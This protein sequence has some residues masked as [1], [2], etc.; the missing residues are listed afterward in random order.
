MKITIT[1]PDSW[2]E[3]K[4][5]QYLEYTK[6]VKPWL[7]SE[8]YAE[9]SIQSALLHFCKVPV[10]YINKLPKAVADKASIKLGELF[11]DI[12][13][14][15][16]VTEFTVGSTMYG[17]I[18]ALNDMTY[19]EYLDLVAYTKKDMWDNIPTIMSILYRPITNRVGKLYTIEPYSGT[20]ETRLELF[21]HVL[22]MDVVFG[23]LS[24][25]LGLQKDLLLGILT[26][27]MEEMKKIKDPEALA[28]LQDLAES[29]Q[30]IAQLQSYLITTLRN[31]TL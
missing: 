12:N 24:F 11:T 17:F 26:Y 7:E 19:G 25:F 5:S 2:A 30:D 9:K 18:P 22:T 21:K 13:K 14:K 4:L 10:E 6:H 27:S 31:S 3:V 1:Y 28:V 8:E 23:A 20:P 15:P 16:L 29:G